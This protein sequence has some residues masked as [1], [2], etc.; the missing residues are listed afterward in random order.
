MRKSYLGIGALVVAIGSF[1]VACIS[2]DRASET[3]RKFSKASDYI[4]KKTGE[5]VNS[6]S[7]EEIVKAV[8]KDAAEKR[9]R[10]IVDGVVKT[11]VNNKVNEVVKDVMGSNDISDMVRKKATSIIS[12]MTLSDFD[13]VLDNIKDD[14]TSSI[15]EKFND[16]IFT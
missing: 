15:K 8:I 6:G 12:G 11:T 5:F 7:T 10:D 14:L 16:L 9:A 4:Y 13:G 3:E 1:V 2:A